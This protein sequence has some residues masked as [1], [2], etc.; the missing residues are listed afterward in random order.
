[1][2]LSI[3]VPFYDEEAAIEDVLRRCVTAAGELAR[4]RPDLAE[5]E[6]IAVDDGS[7]DG[8]AERA[9]RVAGVKLVR[10]E[11]NRGYGAALKSGFD[12]AKGDW[13][14]FLDGDG[15]C[16]PL[17]LG[18]LLDKALAEEL[19]VVIGARLHG[20]SR[21]PVLRTAG[22]R[23]FH[24]LVGALG[25]GDVS[26]VASGIRVLRRTAYEAMAPLPD[27]MAFSPAMSARAILDPALRVGEVPVWYDE[28]VGASKLSAV[29]DGLR[30]L[31]VILETGLVFRPRA[32]FGWCGAVLT[33]AAV[34]LFSFGLGGPEAPLAYVLRERAAAEWMYFRFVLIAVLVSLA[35]FLA[36]LGV[37]LQALVGVVH[38]G[39]DGAF[40][41]PGSSGA[42]ARLFPL[43]GVA[44][45]LAGTAV[46]AEPLASYWRTGH[47][48]HE[49]WV[50]PIVG[51]VLTA[52]GVKL[53]GLWVASRIAEL[54]WRRQRAGTLW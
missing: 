35:F 45:F 28:R 1:M 21:M 52:A 22:N 39:R 24:G 6:V 5:V 8:S 20:G 38:R 16:C 25:G 13:L 19:D 42:L 51:G 3:V 34:L 47:I 50:Q 10:H 37:V 54:L 4:E 43:A 49:H 11:G 36:A 17:S 48:S 32:F 23:L 15:T 26:D 53:W 29:G 46:N 14:A 7:R 18:N 12:S 40:V 2:I 9:A 41:G 31:L 33:A 44:L 27:G 30:F